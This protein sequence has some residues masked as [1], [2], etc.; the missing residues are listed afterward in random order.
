MVGHAVVFVGIQ[1]LYVHGGM[2][3]IFPKLCKQTPRFFSESN[4]VA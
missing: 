3:H 2:A 1:F 4:I